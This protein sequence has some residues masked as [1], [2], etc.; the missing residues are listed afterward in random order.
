ML[1]GLR[2]QAT[3]RINLIDKWDEHSRTHSFSLMF[4]RSQRRK[5]IGQAEG[6]DP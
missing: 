1:E 2:E 5:W 6:R 3:S 4:P